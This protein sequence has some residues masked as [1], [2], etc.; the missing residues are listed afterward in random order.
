[1]RLLFFL[2]YT[3]FSIPVFSQFSDFESYDFHRADSIAEL[4]N[5]YDLRD[6]KKLT[7]LLTKD[8]NSEVE[9]FRAIFK[10]ITNNVSYNIDLF[11][12]STKQEAELRFKKKKLERWRA[13]FNKKILKKLI[14][15]KSTICFGYASLLETMCG[16]TGIQCEI[17]NGYGRTTRDKIGYGKMDHAW[18]AVYIKDKWYLC[19]PTWS[20]GYVDEEYNRF[21]R[22]F[23]KNYFLSDSFMFSVNHYPKNTS[24]LLLHEKPTLKD[25]QNSPL[26]SSGFIESKLNHYT[27]K[28]GRLQIK[29]DSTIRFSFTSNQPPKS[30]EEALVQVYKRINRTFRYAEQNTY[31]LSID[32]EGYYYF[33]HKFQDL[34]TF[35]LE[36]FIGRKLV[37]AY[38]V[39]TK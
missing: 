22:K 17:I 31:K 2:L 13:G 30:I 14:I 4:Y 29:C 21:K 15:N 33:D 10:W 8:L 18:N 37:L 12:E 11:N 35:K 34:G 5:G 1:M 24:W 20:S 7:E 19:D 36:I 27:P 32:K 6:Q 38:E 39:N 9:K 16:F 26:K 28:D 3:V 25:F 23:D